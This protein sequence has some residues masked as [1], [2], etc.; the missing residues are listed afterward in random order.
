[1]T[2]LAGSVVGITGHTPDELL[3]SRDLNY[4]SLCHPE[5]LQPMIDDVDAAIAN[6]ESW[7]IDYRL[8]RRDSSTILVRER[9]AAVRNASGG[10]E[11]LQGLVVDAT[12]E[13]VL[14]RQLQAN[15]DATTTANREI[16]ALAD[17]IAASVRELAILSINARIEAARA[18]EAGRGF[19]V[20]ATEIGNLADKNAGW[21]DEIASRMTR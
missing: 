4:A 16:L 12:N 10:V 9:G 19:S 2:Y 20:V 11:Y 7:D 6:N 3:Y 1:M 15:I 21:A 18:G 14:R 8:I 5:D 13:S 17:N